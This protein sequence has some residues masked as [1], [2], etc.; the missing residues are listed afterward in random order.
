MELAGHGAH[1]G[2]PVARQRSELGPPT[3]S[4]LS[5][6][7]QYVPC[8]TP[9]PRNPPLAVDLPQRAKRRRPPHQAASSPPRCRAGQVA[10]RSRDA[11]I[12]PYEATRATTSP[13]F[14]FVEMPCWARL[15][16]GRRGG[17]PWMACKRSAM[18][19]AALAWPPRYSSVA[20]SPV[21]SQR[22]PR[23]SYRH[24]G[25]SIGAVAAPEWRLR[26]VVVHVHVDVQVP[27][28]SPIGACRG[29]LGR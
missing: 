9:Q 3:V 2:R 17:D 15:C 26:W 28:G 29:L 23:D 21:S 27:N 25:R 11:A 4:R 8:V 18:S 14:G 12:M 20:T 1:A 7:I 5:A 19:D 10:P 24:A 22:P 13:I 16:G 6:T